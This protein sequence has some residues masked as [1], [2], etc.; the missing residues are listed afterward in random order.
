M[1]VCTYREFQNSDHGCHLE[2]QKQNFLVILN[3]DVAHLPPT[4]F[5]FNLSSAL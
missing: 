3:L 4:K 2:H 5:W 1:S